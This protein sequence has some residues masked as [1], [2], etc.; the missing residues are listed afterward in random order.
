VPYDIHTAEI[1]HT[2]FAVYTDPSMRLHS[3]LGMTKL[4]KRVDKSQIKRGSYVRHGNVRGLAMVV[5]NAVRVGM[6]IW[7]K[8]GDSAQLG[9]EF[10]FGPG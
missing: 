6:P 4:G 5:A 1:F 10:V 9:G 7:E 3:A 2:P 8:G